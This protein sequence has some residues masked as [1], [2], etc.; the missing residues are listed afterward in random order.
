MRERGIWCR[1]SRDIALFSLARRRYRG[2]SRRCSGPSAA[3]RHAPAACA[4]PA[5]A[6]RLLRRRF[7]SDTEL[8]LRRRRVSI[9]AGESRSKL[10]AQVDSAFELNFY[11]YRSVAVGTG[12]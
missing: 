4:A 8:R 9:N 2:L 6:P 11:R 1:G 7:L 12:S 5:L 10:I 3:S